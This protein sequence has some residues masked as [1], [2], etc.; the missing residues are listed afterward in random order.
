MTS[1]LDDAVLEC[2]SVKNFKDSIPPGYIRI[3]CQTS[4]CHPVLVDIPEM[5]IDLA[6]GINCY[7][8][9]LPL[10]PKSETKR[11]QVFLVKEEFRDKP[12][13]GGPYG[14]GCRWPWISGE[15]KKKVDKLLRDGSDYE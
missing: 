15:E 14:D 11:Y 2:K 10:P 12:L 6:S 9:A 1:T 7:P 5:W 8:E 4:N 13:P 3:P